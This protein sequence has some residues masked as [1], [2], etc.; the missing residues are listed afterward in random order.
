MN[1]F[2]SHFSQ[3]KLIAI[4]LSAVFL[5][6]ANSSWAQGKAHFSLGAKLDFSTWKG[7]NQNGASFEDKSSMLGLEAKVQHA[8]W[9]GGLTLS[10]GKFEFDTTAPTRLTNPLAASSEPVSIKRGEVDLIL[11]YRVWPRIALF[12]DIKNVTNEWSIDGYKVEYTGIGFGI[13]GHRPVSPEWTLFGNFGVVPM[14]IKADGNDVGDAVRT[15][16]NAGFLYRIN[17]RMN[18][19]IGLQNQ[20]QTDDYDNGSEQ[21]H[22]IGSLTIGI[23]AAL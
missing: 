6:A 20:F 14:N 5:F 4:F 2:T 19:S 1:R 21:T 7:N 23:N 8:K 16:L 17:H 13:S 15:A 3:P 18:L 10:G 22:E 11:G 12:I 9:F